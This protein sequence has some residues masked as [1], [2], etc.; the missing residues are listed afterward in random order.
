MY[1]VAAVSGHRSLHVLP[2]DST[3]LATATLPER[4]DAI[5]NASSEGSGSAKTQSYHRIAIA[6]DHRSTRPR[7]SSEL[8]TSILVS[9]WC[10]CRRMSRPRTPDDL[11]AVPPG[12]NLWSTSGPPPTPESSRSRRQPKASKCRRT[13]LPNVCTDLSEH[14]V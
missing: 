9:L 1:L 14:P 13:R 5:C 10:V 4:F 2:A 12:F 11:G 3:Y 7:F 8:R 6:L